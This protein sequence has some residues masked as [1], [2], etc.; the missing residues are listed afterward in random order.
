[1][2]D[3]VSLHAQGRPDSVALVDAASGQRWTFE[4]LDR[5]VGS[6][7][8]VITARGV[9][10]GD[11]ISAITR[12]SP[13]LIILQLACARTG[14]ILVPLNWRLSDC[15]LG[16]LIADCE[17][18]LLFGDTQLDRIATDIPKLSTGEFREE[19]AATAPVQ[20]GPIEPDRPSLMLY[21]SGTS[22]R[23]KG[24]PLTEANLLATAL[25][26]SVIGE[27]TADSAFLVDSP[28]FHI[29]GMV[30]NIRPAL[31]MGGRIVVS[32]GFDP[33]RTLQRLGDPDL[34]IT[35]YFCV[36]QMAD[37]LRQVPGFDPARLHGLK[38]LFTGGAPHPA[39]K[40]HAWLADGVTVV[41][42][43]G[44]TEA[45]TILGMPVSPG[46]IEQKAGSAGLMPP[47]MER[48]IIDSNGSDCAPG[49]V[50]E[51]ALRGPNVFSGYWRRTEETATAFTDDGFFLTGDLVREDEDG[52]YFLVDRKKDMFISGGENVYPAEVEVALKSHPDVVEAAVVG[53]PDDRWG[54]VGHAFV[55]LRA[56]AS[57][58]GATL[59]RHCE[60]RLARYKLPRQ[61]HILAELPTTGSGKVI[62]SE[63]KKRLREQDGH[64]A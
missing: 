3:F 21:T 10:A 11:R 63:L 35:H 24:V 51:L 29:I 25:N 5:A 46:R 57:I 59:A 34:A 27:V 33:A 2:S 41:D 30:T 31:M 50:G 47:T 8:G 22:G 44:M 23:S 15:E 43:Y 9:T 49:E 36:P 17:P 52:F 62:K 32:D 13:E 39:P 16:A 60:Q 26:F 18:A 37:M 38:A 45:G 1:M 42:G 7:V 40:I 56:D 20:S 64:D 28:M 12:N 4:S 61:V 14:A 6:A 58:D 55:R 19:L 54:E 48:R 53:T